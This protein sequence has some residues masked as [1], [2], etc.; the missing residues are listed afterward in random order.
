MQQEGRLAFQ[1]PSEQEHTAI[2]SR[3]VFACHSHSRAIEKSGSLLCD[4]PMDELTQSR[5]L[6]WSIRPCPALEGKWMVRTPQPKG[7]G[8]PFL[9]VLK[10]TSGKSLFPTL[11]LRGAVWCESLTRLDRCH[12]LK[13]V[14][15][16]GRLTSQTKTWCHKSVC[17]K[18]L[19]SGES[20]ERT[21]SRC[22]QN[23]GLPTSTPLGYE[24]QRTSHQHERITHSCLI[25]IPHSFRAFGP[26]GDKGIYCYNG[27]G[28]GFCAYSWYKILSTVLQEGW[29]TDPAGNQKMT[30]KPEVV[31]KAMHKGAKKNGN[32]LK[33]K[34]IY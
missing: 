10:K 16:T 2:G 30:A 25:S 11:G 27:N 31:R 34:I 21:F 22:D 3:Y 32:F 8:E 18:V 20:L 13:G 15:K 4:L 14:A 9:M 5:K 6:D 17:L 23:D 12:H 1:R 24:N 28:K 29:V 7:K 26:L 19:F 33:I